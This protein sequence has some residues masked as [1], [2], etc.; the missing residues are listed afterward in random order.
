MRRPHSSCRSTAVS[1][2]S[3]AASFHCSR[4]V[5]TC[6]SM[7]AAASA[8]LRLKTSSAARRTTASLEARAPSRVIAIA[9]AAVCPGRICGDRSYAGVRCREV[10]SQ[11][12]E[13]LRAW[14]S[15]LATRTLKTNR[16]YSSRRVAVGSMNRRRTWSASAG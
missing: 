8:S 3:S 7:I 12:A 13:W 6:P 14:S 9:C 16:P 5:V 10:P 15:V 1:R 2:H 11:K 4:T